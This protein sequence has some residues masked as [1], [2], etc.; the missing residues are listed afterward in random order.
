MKLA[1]WNV[2]G[3]KSVLA[4]GFR[5][6]IDEE[7]P[8]IICL[9][10]TKVQPDQV[11]LSGYDGYE[12][13]F[14]PAEKKGYSGT[15]IFTRVRPKSASHGIGDKKHD[16][17]GRVLTLEFAGC[18]LVNCYTPNSQ[19]GLTRLDYRMEWDKAFRQFAS[20][21]AKSKPV[22]LC[23]D[24][25][26]AHA[27]IDLANPRSN[28]RNAG[29]TEEE[30]AG[31]SALLEAGFLDCFRLFD[32]SPGRYTWWTYRGTARQKNVGWRIDYW[33]A[34]S[35]LRDKLAACRILPHLTG[36]DHCPVVLET[37]PALKF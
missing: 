13:M 17:E 9:Q 1:T 37:K 19:R 31:F 11:D 7:D 10:E 28:R 22:L 12:R 32:A 14:H 15:A 20:H 16:R 27:E 18:H 35:A 6:L 5:R 2:N 29:F 3:L 24:F 23:G 25:N 30:R 36:S 8:D 4:K 26:V 33:C 34:S 21:L